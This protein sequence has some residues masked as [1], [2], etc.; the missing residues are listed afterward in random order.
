M[1]IVGFD[2]MLTPEAALKLPA[3]ATTLV[4]TVDELAESVD[5]VSLHTPY[6]KGVTHH[7]INDNFLARLK[8]T[9]HILNFARGEIVDSDAMV[10]RYA[11]GATGR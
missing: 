6:I 5:F 1:K 11:A 4:E 9:A 10:K 2:P 3:H 7:M 8:P